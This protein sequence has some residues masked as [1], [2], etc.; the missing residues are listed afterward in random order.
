[1][2][3]RHAHR[4]LLLAA[5]SLATLALT[6][7]AAGAAGWT[8]GPPISAPGAVAV[9]PLAAVSPAGERLVAWTRTTPPNFNHTGLAVRVAPPGADFG[10]VQLIND[11]GVEDP[12]L[13]VG[14][15]GTAALVWFSN[16]S[17]HVAT[18]APGKPAFTEASPFPLGGFE[19]T[20]AKAVVVG[21]D[22]YVAATSRSFAGDVE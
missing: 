3:P 14:A 15:D 8:T 2:T 7:H 1:M 21:G 5:A 9:T 13:T 17:L 6:P 11:T 16:T 19:E 18:R 10:D 22:V 20:P 4:L 12:S